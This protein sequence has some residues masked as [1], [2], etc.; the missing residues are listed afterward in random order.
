M[1]GKYTKGVYL[2]KCK[3]QGSEEQSG[4]IPG[5]YLTVGTISAASEQQVDVQKKPGGLLVSESN[6]RFVIG[7]VH[8]RP[9]LF[10]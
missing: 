5:N 9:L 2:N 6:S 7:C 3:K 10:G 8:A 1:L 4:K